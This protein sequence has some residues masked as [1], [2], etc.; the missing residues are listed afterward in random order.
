[1]AVDRITEDGT[2]V[3]SG[4][5]L[6]PGE[7]ALTTGDTYTTPWIVITA[8]NDG[9]D[10]VAHSLHAWERS[11]PAHPA[12]Q[13]VTLN[14]WEA[15][16]FDQDPD[17]VLDLVGRAARLGVERFVLDDGWF[18]ARRTDT[19][20]LGDWWVDRSVW[21]DGLKPLADAI[22][23]H[24]MEFGLWFEPEMVNPDSD[25][26]REHPDWVL[27]STGRLPLPHRNQ[28]VL[29]LTNPDAFAHVLEQIST[30]LGECAVDYVKWDHNRDLLEAGGT[31]RGGAPAV[32]D[33]TIGY[34]RLIDALR[35]RFPRI[36]WESCA[37]GGGR[38]D[39]G[40]IE[41]VS[42]VWTSD[43]T[44]ALSRQ[45]IQRGMV[46]SVAPEYLGAHVSATTSHQTGRTYT[47]AFRAATAVFGSFGIEWDIR[48]AS[49]SD[50]DEL[51]R[52]IAWY[53]AERGFL[54]SGR[55]VRLDV[56]DPA[57]L[58]HGVVA[59]DRS[60]AIIAHVQYEESSSN[61]GVWLRIPGLDPE[62][63][64][65]LRWTGPQP[66][67]DASRPDWDPILPGGPLGFEGMRPNR[68]MPWYFLVACADGTVAG[69]GVRVRPNALCFWQADTAGLTLEMDV[70]NGG[71]GV[72]LDDEPLDLA[73]VVARAYDDADS[74]EAARRFCTAM[75]DDSLLP[76]GPV[77][78]SNNWY[79]AYG[80][81][82]A[83][84]I[85]GDAAY[86][87]SLTADNAVRPYMVIDD[88]WQSN[89]RLGD[90]NGGPWRSGNAKFPDMAG[91]ARRIA[92][93]G[94]RPGI[95]VRLLLN[96]DP[97][98]PDDWRLP[99]GC[100]DPTHPDALAYIREDVDTLCRWGYRLIKH[101]F[102][103]YDLFGRWGFQMNPWMAAESDWHYHDRSLTAAQVVKR[104]YEAILEVARPYGALILGCNT[105]GHLG[106]G[107]MH[108]ARTADDER[109]LVESL[110]IASERP[111]HLRPLDWEH[112]DCPETWGEDADA[113]DDGDGLRTVHYDWYDARGINYTTTPKRYISY[114]AFDE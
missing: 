81:S 9:L 113:R 50:L 28:Q 63:R 61:R 52:W 57:V 29:D 97:S 51:S 23:D 84:N 68:I 21:P 46:Q 72:V 89:H 2:A 100:L 77:Y 32:H 42:R 10:G 37:S 74:F 49:E 43:M 25:L 45:R 94:V 62:A 75:C 5:L 4:E 11:L 76:D 108:I 96:E 34:Y 103:T 105:I 78:G 98:I 6:Q 14:V 99:N 59:G 83:D 111:S 80:V 58:A 104:L 44:D 41:H 7:V 71:A 35:E 31:L 95:W 106:A 22:H 24:G 8:C 53:K 79:Y 110:R 15:L 36:A 112:T 67:G 20:G 27:Q 47:L 39:L 13:P 16:Y 54:H 26:Y 69:Y 65:A 66:A 1:M 92:D 91:L 87:A 70:R 19:A 82:S 107:L 85:A 64:Y 86:L 3:F 73:T 38:V 56:A 60:R 33:H 93:Q 101:D 17:V 40:V 12:S 30:V 114:L 102:S 109:D 18:H 88:G 90:Y 55:V 48:K